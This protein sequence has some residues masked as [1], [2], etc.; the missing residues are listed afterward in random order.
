MARGVGRRS[1]QRHDPQI[2][3]TAAGYYLRLVAGR[4]PVELF[5]MLAGVLFTC[6]LAAFGLLLGTGVP[7]SCTADP[8]S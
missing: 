1:S 6:Y 2:T 4:T 5:L 8:C 3:P 7:R